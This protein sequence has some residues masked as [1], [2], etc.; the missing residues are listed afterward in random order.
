MKNHDILSLTLSAIVV[1]TIVGYYLLLS[2]RGGT[3]IKEWYKQF[4]IGAYVMDILS[5][6]IGTYS[7]T[8]FSNNIYSQIVATVIVGLIHDISFGIFVNK[9]QTQSKILTLFKNYA[10]ELGSTI[11]IVDALMLIST[12]LFSAYFKTTLTN[13]SMTFLSVIVFYLGLLMI[14]SF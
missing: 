12:L 3:Y 10:N 1:D 14:Y 6:I 9:I 11:L 2:T 8:L 13:N 7:A 5:I 4:N